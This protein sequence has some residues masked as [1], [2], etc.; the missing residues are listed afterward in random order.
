MKKTP[1]TLNTGQTV[2]LQKGDV[3]CRQY[4]EVNEFYFLIEGTIKIY[5]NLELPRKEVVVGKTS[6]VYTPIGWSGFNHPNRYAS[7]VVVSS[8]E[9]T[10]LKWSFQK[11]KALTEEDPELL[12]FLT[13]QA[14]NLLKEST[15]RHAKCA[16]GIPHEADQPESFYI[17]P[18]FTKKDAIKLLR[19]SPFFGNVGPKYFIKLGDLVQKR[20]YAAG[21]IIYDQ[22]VI[23]QGIFILVQGQVVLSR[24]EEGQDYYPFRSISTPSFLVG[25]SALLDK[26]TIVQATAQRDTTVY[27]I[28]K[29]HLETL[30][31][32]NNTF[33]RNINLSLLW[34]IGNQLQVTRSRLIHQKTDKDNIAVQNL[35]E[36]NRVK[37]KLSSNIHKVPHLLKHKDTIQ[38]GLN[39]LHELNESG[40]RHE[41]HISSLCLD[42]LSS[43]KRENRFYEGLKQVYNTVTRST[44]GR[45]PFDV[46][47]D[48][49]ESFRT[50]FD[51]VDFNIMGWENL[52]DQSGNIFIYN[53]I[54]NH[55]HY[56]LPNNFQITLDSHFISAHILFE[57]Y[58]DP[59][60]RIV[61]IGRGVEYA[62]QEYY[63]RLGHI[64]VYTQD[65]HMGS[66]K[67]VEETRKSFYED[68]RYHL[69]KGTNIII[70]P[71][72]VSNPTEESPG[73]LKS[74][75]FRLAMDIDPEPLIVPITLAYFDR[76]VG[77][78]QFFCAIQEPFRVSDHVSEA[79]DKS[80]MKDFLY[81]LQHQMKHQ[82]N[83]TAKIPEL[84]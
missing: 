6:E 79:K 7:T 78:S 59:G 36:H 28:D 3:I 25:W 64:N 35:I 60:L 56:T 82:V 5:V 70:S 44:K 12:K 2:R 22:G 71:E 29:E 72:G 83:E 32:E 40:E 4:E 42:L 48:C 45:D 75:A 67:E 54:L 30:R 53:H 33:N 73:P 76:R 26:A 66:E 81:H 9:A 8:K 49:A 77:E 80:Q 34:L 62:H 52:P 21:E 27:F 10:L 39:M 24:M 57:K 51:W 61:R 13:H 1:P 47:V 17:A 69:N 41:K 63:R 31:Q 14:F 19:K 23:Q 18:E 55:P 38:L 16:Y 43:T 68:S 58:G 37:F 84:V 50:A 11:L 74:G 65:S 20:Q 46:R 15:I